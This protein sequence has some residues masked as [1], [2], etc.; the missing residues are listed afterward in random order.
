MLGC[1]PSSVLGRSGSGSNADGPELKHLWK[2]N[3]SSRS[4]FWR[5]FAPSAHKRTHTRQAGHVNRK[6]KSKLGGSSIMN[7]TGKI[8]ILGAAT[9]LA[10]CALHNSNQAE[11]SPKTIQLAPTPVNTPIHFQLL[12]FTNDATGTKLA[13][14]ELRNI[15]QWPLDVRLPG[16][17]DADVFY[18]WSSV[19]KIG[20]SNVTLQA[21]E[22]VETSISV[23]KDLDRWR[24][25]VYWSIPQ[26]MLA[27][28]EVSGYMAT[29]SEYLPSP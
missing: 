11:S 8:I 7:K 13:R 18:G 3:T 10:G 27:S 6:M 15:K 2:S 9:F 1:L 17:V 22:S 14:F 28:N 23:P 29:F 5:L 12:N 25:R 20:D 19:V 26:N 4:C 21:G 16:Y 24:V